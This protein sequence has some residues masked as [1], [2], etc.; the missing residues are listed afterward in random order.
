MSTVNIFLK[1]KLAKAGAVNGSSTMEGHQGDMLLDT[2]HWGEE[3]S[4]VAGS[5]GGNLTVRNFEFTKKMCPGSVQL[6][7]ACASCDVVQEAIIACRATNVSEKVDFLKWTLG[8]GMVARY[9]IDASAKESVVP[10]ER[11][12]IR[13][14]TLAVEYKPRNTKGTLDAALTARLDLAANTSSS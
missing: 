11:V 7:L 3:N 8:D 5:K 1:L 9:E 13:F 4:G 6:L 12:S 14:R 2:I 10:T